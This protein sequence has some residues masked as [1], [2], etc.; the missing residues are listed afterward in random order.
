MNLMQKY[1]TL[2]KYKVTCT[3]NI[4]LCTQPAAIVIVIVSYIVIVIIG[5]KYSCPNIL[6][7][8]LKI[9]KT[10]KQIKFEKKPHRRLEE[11]HESKVV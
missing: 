11:L 3:C 9:E 4:F 5:T 8:N 10:S 7:L 6:F 2:K 1:V